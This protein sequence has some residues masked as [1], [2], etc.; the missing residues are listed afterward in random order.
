MTNDREEGITMTFSSAFGAIGAA[1]VLGALV[2]LLRPHLERKATSPPLSDHLKRAEDWLQANGYHV[3]RGRQEAEWIGYHDNDEFRK[4][5]AVDF[6][7]R[8]GADYYAVKV[9]Q[10]A[11]VEV[12]GL[13]LREE[14]FPVWNAFSVKGILHLDVMEGRAHTI[15]F[16][17]KVPRYVG[18]RRLGHRTGW[19]LAGALAMFAWLHHA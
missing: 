2:V 6:I 14:W 7:A 10:M 18:V 12:S 4:L 13:R 9:T 3:V 16:D 1:F 11:E 8:K 15:D 5:L 19:V 17:L